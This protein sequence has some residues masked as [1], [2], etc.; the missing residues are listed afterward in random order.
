MKRTPLIAASLALSAASS[1]AGSS[2]TKQFG[3]AGGLVIQYEVT[4]AQTGERMSG[5]F[6]GEVLRNTVSGTLTNTTRLPV[7]CTTIRPLIP[8]LVRSV[9]VVTASLDAGASQPFTYISTNIGTGTILKWEVECATPLDYQFSSQTVTKKFAAGILV[10]NLG[11]TQVGIT[12]E[13]TSDQPIEIVWNESSFIDMNRSARRI[14]HSG[15]KYSKR[16]EALPNTT[17]P[18][19]AKVEDVVI[20][21]ENV[22]FAES[23]WLTAPLFT[24]ELPP[25]QAERAMSMKGAKVALFLQLLVDGKKTSVTLVFEVAAV[26]PADVR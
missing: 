26:R 18:P 15:V 11:K 24:S 12:V 17:V 1:C 20:P 9:P 3:D 7:R 4:S 19:L 2:Y 6:E 5:L 8:R 22:R 10:G 23:E 21:T 13:N 14:F 25:E 16:D